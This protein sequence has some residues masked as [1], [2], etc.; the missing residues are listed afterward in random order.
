MG[1]GTKR[2]QEHE[3]GRSVADRPPLAGEPLPLD[4]VNTT[5]IKGGVRGFL[6]DALTTPEELDLWLDEH[7]PRFSPTLA[8]ALAVAGPDGRARQGHL[9]RFLE[10]RRALRELAAARVEDRAPGP[11]DCEVVNAA[12]R[13]AAPRRELAPGPSFAV[14]TR[15]PEADPLLVALGEV[16]A[17]AVDLLTGER[18]GLLRA[19]PAPGCILY[20]VKG[21]ARRE[22]CTVG[23]GN[24]V[25]VARHSRRA[26]SAVGAG[27]ADS[28]AGTG[29]AAP[30]PPAAAG[31][32]RLT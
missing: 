21:H 17:G 23:C 15:W 19:C 30:A 4:L 12:V 26:G 32:E 13:S 14:A 22:W 2:D 8:G 6:V 24:R 11:A 16:A 31:A 25:R 27:C 1:D 3:R 18:A 7:R 9:D 5:F 10:L 28:A 20:F 29:A